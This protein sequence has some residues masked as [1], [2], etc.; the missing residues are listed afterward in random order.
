[1]PL[2]KLM[3]FNNEEQEVKII[4][5]GELKALSVDKDFN[6]SYNES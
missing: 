4:S 3:N 6:E 1:M 2:S 5:L